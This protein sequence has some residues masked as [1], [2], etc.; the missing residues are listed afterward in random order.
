MAGAAPDC[1][2]VIDSEGAFCEEGLSRFVQQHGV[3]DARTNY[4][5]VAIM[6]PQSSGKSTLMNHVVRGCWRVLMGGLTERWAAKWEL[7]RLLQGGCAALRCGCV[8]SAPA[9]ASPHAAAPCCLLPSRV[10]L[11]TRSLARASRRWTP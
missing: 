2:Q 5:V 1:C 7:R 9:S 10:P 11:P 6:G 8:R 4:Q 3:I